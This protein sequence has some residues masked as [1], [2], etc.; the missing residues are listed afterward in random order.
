[1]VASSRSE[2]ATGIQAVASKAPPAQST[3]IPPLARLHK[4]RA[5]RENAEGWLPFNS[6]RNGDI[7]VWVRPIFP[8]PHLAL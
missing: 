4:W 2:K 1:M 7:P 3:A 6:G 8:P 5:M